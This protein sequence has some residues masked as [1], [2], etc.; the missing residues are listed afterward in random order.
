M[1]FSQDDSILHSFSILCRNHC[2][3][4]SKHQSPRTGEFPAVSL[5][6]I[7]AVSVCAQCDPSR[8]TAPCAAPCVGSTARRLRQ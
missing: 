3:N 7:K 8:A 4:P 2:G 5:R 1:A 6:C